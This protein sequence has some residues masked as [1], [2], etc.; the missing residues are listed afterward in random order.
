[1]ISYS[2]ARP[3]SSEASAPAPL[4]RFGDYELLKEIARGGMGVVYRARQVGLNRDVALK[5]I[6]S[7]PF[8]SPIERQR[9]LL[10]AEVAAH[11]DHPHIV[12]IYEVGEHEGQHFLCM[13]LVDGGSLSRQVSRLLQE[14]RAAA[15]L[16]VKV[17]RA[18]HYAHQHGFLHRDLKPSNIL[19]D[20]EGQPHVTDFGLARR[21]EGASALTQTGAVVGTPSYMAPEQ[22]AGQRGSLTV[23]ADVYSLG[24]ILYE[25]LTGRPPFRAE[26]VM[27]T[28]V[29]VLE[30]EPTPPGRIRPGVSRDLEQI[31]LKCLEKAPEARYPSAAALGDDLDRY[32]RGEYATARQAGSWIR[33]RRWARR[34]PELAFRLAALGVMIALTHFNHL[35]NPHPD[36]KIHARV[37]ATLAIWALLSIAFQ[38]VLRTGWRA[39]WVRPA[40][41]GVDV[42]LL[43]LI[44]RIL[45]ASDSTLVVG[46]PLLVAASGLWFRVRLVWL[47]T[48][49]AEV[50]YGA[51]AFDAWARG[52][53]AEKAQWPNIFMA[54]LAVTGFIVA[55]QV[56][57]LWA[58]SFYYEHRPIS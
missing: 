31:C 13:K 20:A 15:R 3:T 41:L 45:D 24:A 5:M 14:P 10:E 30:Q 4:R 38:G 54:A 43:S 21:V 19:L 47:T 56:K 44:V 29:Q 9:F 48:L 34:E 23:A 52:V 16:L 35:R 51:L 6:L 42:L 8:A 37:I 28:V 2:S 25:L 53:T 22:A 7:G 18:V 11:F 40:W 55:H 26:T 27:E 50:A 58:L 49:L 12:P 17:A 46:Y 1:T 32:L 33:F 57:R 36:P 39:R